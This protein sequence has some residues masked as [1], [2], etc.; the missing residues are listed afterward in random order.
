MRTKGE[1]LRCLAMETGPGSS[2][3]SSDRLAEETGDCEG[4]IG[5]SFRDRPG[6]GTRI[7]SSSYSD[8]EITGRNSPAHLRRGDGLRLAV[9]RQLDTVNASAK[10]FCHT[11]GSALPIMQMNGKLL[12]V[13][14]GS[15]DSEVLIRPNAHIFV[16]SRASRDDSLETV[17]TV[18]GFPP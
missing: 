10:C 3:A 1:R 6:L 17:P 7:R 16:S 4:E 5:R 12:V 14:A 18:D 2:T 15:L 8:A 11:C 13:P 9:C